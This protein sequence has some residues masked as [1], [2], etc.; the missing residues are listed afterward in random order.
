MKE[1]LTLFGGNKKEYQAAMKLYV[2]Q[3]TEAEQNS[4]PSPPPPNLKYP[5][6]SGYELLSK[7]LEDMDDLKLTGWFLGFFVFVVTAMR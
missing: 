1:L 3:K 5:W 2:Q 7:L 6:I 4:Q